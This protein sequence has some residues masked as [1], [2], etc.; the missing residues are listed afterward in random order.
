MSHKI[1][2]KRT[3]TSALRPIVFASGLLGLIGAAFLGNGTLAAEEPRL[4]PAA[5][6][7]VAEA[8]GPQTAIFAGGCFWGIQGVFQHVQGVMNATAG[9]TGGTKETA[10]YELTEA[11]TTGHA[12]SVE[13]VF[14]P[15]KVTY[16]KLLQIYFSAAHDPTQLNRQGADVGT[17]YRSAIFPVNEEQAKVAADYI[18]QLENDKV[19]KDKIAT[20][21][22]L[23]KPFYEA[24][25][26][27]QDYMFNNPTQPYIM[28]T[29]QPKV[30]ALKALFPE[31]YKE[32]PVLVADRQ[33]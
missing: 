24:E 16:G 8:D 23:G 10:A 20:S 22:E 18:A 21:I 1:Q 19:F 7:D 9:Y 14:D 33:G 2:S 15:H 17:Q 3:V 31:L 28:F 30:Q 4:V 32:K 6:H 26:Y 12:E 29:E 5:V 13:I 25:A 11:G 27:H